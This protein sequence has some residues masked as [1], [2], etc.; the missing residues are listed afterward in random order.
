LPCYGSTALV[1]EQYCEMERFL[2]G[3]YDEYWTGQ[4]Q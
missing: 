1:N 2:T 4:R 3:C